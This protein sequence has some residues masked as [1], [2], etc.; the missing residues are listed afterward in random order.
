MVGADGYVSNFD[1]SSKKNRD[2]FL[3]NTTIFNKTKWTRKSL[4]FI[5]AAILIKKKSNSP[6]ASL[7]DPTTRRG[8]SRLM[9][10][11]LYEQTDGPTDRQKK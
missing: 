4:L 11:N 10:L 8:Y 3:F 5:K 6:C 7:V 2:D 9:E 1:F